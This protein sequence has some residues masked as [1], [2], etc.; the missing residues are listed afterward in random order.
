MNKKDL[1]SLTPHINAM[2]SEFQN[3]Y[4]RLAEIESEDKEYLA[5]YKIKLEQLVSENNDLK[6]DIRYYKSQIDQLNSEKSELKTRIEQLKTVYFEQQKMIPKQR[7]EPEKKPISSGNNKIQVF[8]QWA[9]EPSG[10]IPP[11]FSYVC[12]ELKRRMNQTFELVSVPAKWIVD[13]ENKILFPN[14]NFLDEVTDISEF[15]AMDVKLLKPK[16]RNRIR[17]VTPCEIVEDGFIRF[18]GELEII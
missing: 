16:G 11:G 12:G 13:N 8:N 15:Y 17:I 6:T 14:P 3:L 18:A 2:N 10:K 7:P 9:A 1:E 4:K 5:K